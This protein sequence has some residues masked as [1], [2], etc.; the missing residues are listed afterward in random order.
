MQSFEECQFYKNDLNLR[1][2]IQFCGCKLN[3]KIY[4]R[5]ALCDWICEKGLT[6]AI[7]NIEKSSFEILNTVYLENA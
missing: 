2:T 4:T 5:I 1:C 7:I 6:C 3:S